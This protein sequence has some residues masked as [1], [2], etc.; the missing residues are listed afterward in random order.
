MIGRRWMLPLGWA[1]VILALTSVPG[2]AVPE[3]AIESG[4]KLVHV[5]LYA[6]LGALTLR[7]AGNSGHPIRTV[8]IVGMAVSLFGIVDELHQLFVPG[9]S[10]DVIDWMADTIGGM[11]GAVIASAL[12]LGTEQAT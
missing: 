12:G 3:V 1:A 4:D 5:A 8:G 2:S 10:A 9:R 6:I 11:T 7:A